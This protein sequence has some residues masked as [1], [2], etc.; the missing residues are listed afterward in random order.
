MAMGAGCKSD[1]SSAK[2]DAGP[3]DTRR[4]DGPQPNTNRDSASGSC[5]ILG[6]TYQ[7][8]QTVTINCV[9]YTCQGADTVTTRGAACVPDAAP[10]QPDA[11]SNRDSAAPADTRVGEAGGPGVDGGVSKDTQ[12]GEAGSVKLDASGADILLSEDTAPVAP[13]DTAAPDVAVIKYD[14]PP[15]ETCKYDG[16]KYLAGG[17][18]QFACGNC[19]CVCDASAIVVQVAGTCPAV[20]AL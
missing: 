1:S 12:L 9:T 19:T 13:A 15:T 14:A 8:G 2:K 16:Q 11:P 4:S 7:A 5:E 6:N 20:D 18:V 17:G 10:T 3:A